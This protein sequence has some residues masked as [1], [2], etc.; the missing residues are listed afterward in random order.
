MPPRRRGKS[1]TE[2]ELAALDLPQNRFELELELVQSLASPAYLHFLATSK[3]LADP[4][5]L[6][7]LS[8]L[9]YW[10]EPEYSRF[11]IYPGCLHFLDLLVNN[12]SFRREL[13]TVPFRNFLH[14]QQFYSW[15]YR[16]RHLFGAQAETDGD[17]N[18]GNG[19]T[20][21]GDGAQSPATTATATATKMEE[22]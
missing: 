8:Y 20:K 10:G 22:Q 6:A 1:M 13:A 11:L 3:Y 4:S 19:G 14:E 9:Q 15:Q 18:D 16:S 5:F 17:N 12:A 2:E 7:F 21:T